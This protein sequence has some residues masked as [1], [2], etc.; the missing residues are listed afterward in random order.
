MSSTR[1]RGRP[2]ASI[3]IW[4]GLLTL[5]FVWGS[6]YLGIRIS[7]ESM[8]S[9][10]MAAGRFLLAGALL[11]GWCVFREGRPALRVTRRELRDSLIVGGA[12]LGGGMGMVALG[13]RTVPAG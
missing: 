7:V 9:F 6:T 1:S 10:L 13:E 8:P 2:A 11:L 5:Y 4:G 3:A 12:L